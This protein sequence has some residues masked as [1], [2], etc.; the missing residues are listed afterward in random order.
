MTRTSL[1]L[2]LVHVYSWETNP[3]GAPNRI[4]DMNWSRE[5]LI[6]IIFGLPSFK[7]S[8]KNG[9]AFCK[10]RQQRVTGGL[11]NQGHS[12][13]EEEAGKQ[14]LIKMLPIDNA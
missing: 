2:L 9:C 1:S 14:P 6:E 7:H 3:Y 4:L 11:E 8:L 12:R 10:T 13:K 5:L